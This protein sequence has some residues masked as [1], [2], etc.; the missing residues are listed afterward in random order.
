MSNTTHQYVM[1][2]DEKRCIGCQ[3]CTI[4]CKVIN[5]VP[6]GFSRVQV[7]IRSPENN[8]EKL[9][10]YQ[11]VRV[12]CQ[13][14]EDAPCVSVCPTG[15]SYRDE[16]GI[17][18]ID[19]AKC[20]GCNYC[21]GACPYHIRY[22][23]PQSGNADKCN[24]CADTRLKAGQAPACVSVCPTDALKFGRRD[25]ADIQ[26]WIGQKE[27]YQQQAQGY[28]AVSLYRRREVHQEENI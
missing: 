27:V 28:G 1:L 6:E 24:F 25:E 18:R 12:S 16:D 2:H 19:K 14:C 21:V 9:G 11:F 7:Q 26:R 10:H 4:A 20:I 8:P 3:A 5:N 13:Q 22:I 17:V 23:D 15:A